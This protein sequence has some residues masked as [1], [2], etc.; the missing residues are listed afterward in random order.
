MGTDPRPPTRA[1]RSVGVCVAGIRHRRWRRSAAR[2]RCIRERP[3][4]RRRRRASVAR[5][6]IH[7]RRRSP[8]RWQRWTG[9]GARLCVLARSVRRVAG[10]DWQHTAN[11]GSP[12]HDRRRDPARLLRPRGGQVV[13]RRSPDRHRAAH[14]GP[15]EQPPGC[16]RGLVAQHRRPPEAGADAGTGGRRSTRDAAGDPRVDGAGAVSDRG[17]LHRSARCVVG[18][19]WRLLDARGLSARALRA[20]GRRWPGV[21][22]CLREPGEPPAGAGDDPPEGV[23]GT[24]GSWCV[25]WA[26]GSAAA[27]GERVARDRGGGARVR[28]RPRRKPRDRARPLVEPIAGVRRRLDRLARARIHRR[29]DDGDGGAVRDGAGHSLDAR[30]RERGAED[31]RPRRRER[32]DPVQPGEAPRVRADCAVARARVWREPV[33]AQLRNPGNARPG[34]QRERRRAGRGQ[35]RPGRHPAGAAAA[36]LRADRS[37][38]A[39]DSRRGVGSRRADSAGA[40]RHAEQ[41]REGGRIHADQSAGH[42]A[43]L[44]PRQRRLL[45]GDADAVLRG[46]GLQ[47]PRHGEFAS[48][49]DYQPGGGEQVSFMARA[50]SA[51]SST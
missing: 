45:S 40:R 48:R 1:G 34:F 50:Q 22:D 3:L 19:D 29:R 49:R 41:P 16:A 37:G 47:R 21:D 35:P 36:R 20:H 24:P 10:G 32:L 9:G 28:I 23:R 43:A 2:V 7:R 15:G 27:H 25:A 51:M 44:E 8:R 39:G 4:L 31:R 5:P 18:V 38:A 12:V 14:P 42:A 13:R 30:L 6:H 11:R 33:R 17:A 46:P 26:A